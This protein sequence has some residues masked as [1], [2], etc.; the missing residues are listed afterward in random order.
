M[1]T[2]TAVNVSKLSNICKTWGGI[3]NPHVDRHCFD[4]VPVSD[5]D[6]HK[7]IWITIDDSITLQCGHQNAE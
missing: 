2:G 5:L 6:Q 4:D 1:W 7:W 3:H